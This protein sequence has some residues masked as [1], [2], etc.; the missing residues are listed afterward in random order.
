MVLERQLLDHRIA[1]Q[2]GDPSADID[3]RLIHGVAQGPVRIA[4]HDEGSL[5]TH[6]TGH[7]PAVAAD[8]ECAAFDAHA[9]TGSRV[10]F[11]DDGSTT[12]R[13]ARAVA[14]AALHDQAA[15]HHAFSDAP[16]RAA[17]DM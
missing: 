17:A 11:D 9:C 4:A 13:G 8:E 10:A 2:V 7:V 16:A 1:A 14:G 12:D 3:D 5:L 6:K 15:A